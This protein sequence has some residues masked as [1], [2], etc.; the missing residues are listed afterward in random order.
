MTSKIASLAEGIAL[1][2]NG[3]TVALG[4]HTLRRHP[5]AAA[6]EIIRQRKRDLHILGWN[7]GIEFDLLVGAGCVKIVE[8]SYV[9]ISGFG[10]AKNY[11]RAA[12]SG[13]IEIREHSEI[14]A[15]DMFRAGA[16]GMA[17]VASSVLAGTDVPATNP[18]IATVTDPFTGRPCTA[19]AGPWTS[20]CVRWADR[21][22][23]ASPCDAFDERSSE[24]SLRSRRHSSSSRRC[25]SPA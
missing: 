3:D 6:G 14:S 20:P 11:R 8:T 18:R 10:L 12:E 1:V 19:V 17:F 7:S 4:G 21:Q 5:M 13:E 16:S 25:S 23:A 15:L 24:V 22:Q 2:R 9:G